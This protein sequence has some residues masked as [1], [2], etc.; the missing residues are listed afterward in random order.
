MRPRQTFHGALCSLP[1]PKRYSEWPPPPHRRRYSGL[2]CRRYHPGLATLK[3]P[4][5]GPAINFDDAMRELQAAVDQAQ[6]EALAKRQDLLMRL[7]A[8]DSALAQEAANALDHAWKFGRAAQ[9]EIERLH[10]LMPEHSRAR[11]PVPGLCA[12]SR[13]SAPPVEGA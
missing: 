9:A 8:D 5:G 7:R 3:R 10:R 6:A 1:D 11:E 4:C 2:T 12:S 13:T